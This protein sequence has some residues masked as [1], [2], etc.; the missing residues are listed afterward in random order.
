MHKIWCKVKAIQHYLQGEYFFIPL[1]RQLDDIGHLSGKRTLRPEEI[2]KGVYSALEIDPDVTITSQF[3]AEWDSVFKCFPK[4]FLELSKSNLGALLEMQTLWK[5]YFGVYVVDIQSSDMRLLKIFPHIQVTT[6]AK[7][8]LQLQSSVDAAETWVD[9]KKSQHLYEADSESEDDES[10]DGESDS[11]VDEEIPKKK[12]VCSS[13]QKSACLPRT[14]TKR[15]IAEDD[16]HST[17]PH[18]R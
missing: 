18:T 16:A 7:S 6:K 15:K 2:S 1:R 17:P 11:E 14:S 4:V 10:E 3:L 9:L 5:D 13:A 12:T 8:V